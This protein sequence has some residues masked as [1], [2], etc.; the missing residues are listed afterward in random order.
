MGQTQAT[1]TGEENGKSVTDS[2]LSQAVTTDL[3][4]GGV[5][6]ATVNTTVDGVSLDGVVTEGMGDGD[7]MISSQAYS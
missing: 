7:N 6:P 3:N 1:F 4:L 5:S 2:P